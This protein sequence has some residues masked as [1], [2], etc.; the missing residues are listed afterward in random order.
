MLFSLSF[1]VIRKLPRLFI[2][3]LLFIS[4]FLLT[5]LLFGGTSESSVYFNSYLIEYRF[6]PDASVFGL[7][8]DTYTKKDL[9]ELLSMKVRAG[10]LGICVDLN[11][12]TLCAPRGNLT[13]FDKYSGISSFKT[14][15]NSTLPSA[16]SLVELAGLFSNRIVHPYILIATDILTAFSFIFILW[17]MF[18]FLPA[19]NL[20]KKILLVISPTIALLWGLGERTSAMS[21]STPLSQVQTPTPAQLV[22]TVRYGSNKKYDLAKLLNE[23]QLHLG[24][25]W[26]KY[27]VTLSKFL[28][29]K[30]ARSELM[31]ELNSILSKEL[32][33][34][35]NRLLL[36]ILTNSAKEG[37]SHLSN[38]LQNVFWNKRSQKG[39]PNKNGSYE[40][41]KADIMALL[42]RERRRIKSI[43]RESGKRGMITSSITL[44]RQS[45][46]PKVPY[47]QDKTKQLTTPNNTL[48]W[49]QE[50]VN[51]Y[52]T[53]LSTE[54]YGLPDH[55]SLR[56]RMTMT[57]RENGLLGQVNDHAI[58][59]L[60]SG[61]ES[62]L[63]NII[64]NAVDTS[65][66]RYTKYSDEDVLLG[67]GGIGPQPPRRKKRKLLL[68][69]ENLHNTLEIQ[70]HLSEPNGAL[71]RLQN[72]MLQNEDM[73]SPLPYEIP[74]KP[75]APG[76]KF[77][78]Y[79]LAPN[80]SA[81][82]S[83]VKLEIKLETAVELPAQGNVGTR[84]ELKWM[85]H[86]LLSST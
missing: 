22:S 13:A 81:E 57:M 49:S 5:F 41:L 78:T 69:A 34:Y 47:V 6:N 85:L 38:D 29:G 30:L 10:Y 4:I 31:D 1:F 53:P 65:R 11:G 44:T 14:G 80:G 86:E 24:T 18:P 51:G 84:S 63:K 76:D 25:N 43:T 28:V 46:L 16:L 2:A 8:Q 52:Q 72:V 75:E 82:T 15:N 73:I 35:H 58:N 83:D 7:I 56:S 48:Q 9:K 36:I 79:G 21:V 39:K 42:L 54:T 77:L 50:V 12:T 40:K 55:D 71:F 62:Y 68:T 64:E 37:P 20:S 27:Q 59:I 60:I 66:Y 3:L 45:L 17:S 74:E 23:F 19:N 70:P 32:I 61:L 26:A 67:P 33:V